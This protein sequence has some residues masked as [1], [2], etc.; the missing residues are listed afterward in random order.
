MRKKKKRKKR[1]IEFKGQELICK[2]YRRKF[3]G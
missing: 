2:R 3:G 1:R